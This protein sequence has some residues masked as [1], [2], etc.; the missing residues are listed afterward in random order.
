LVFSC[1]GSNDARPIVH[2]TMPP[3]SVRYWT[4]PARA[5][6]TAVVTSGRHGADLRIRHQSARAEDLAQLA[7]DLH[8][9]RRRDHDVEIHEAFL[10]LRREI[11]EADDVGAGVLRRLR[12]LALREHRDADLLPGAGRQHDRAAHG[13]IDFFASTPRLTATSTDSSNLA[14]AVSLTSFSASSIEY[15]FA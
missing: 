10:D 11:V 1:S 3:L 14:T 5:F 12:L 7:D 8:R 13:L 6:L 2:W 4:W 9:I 15:A